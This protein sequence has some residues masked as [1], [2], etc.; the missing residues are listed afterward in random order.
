MT[1]EPFFVE[2]IPQLSRER[3]QQLLAGIT[4]DLPVTRIDAS[5]IGK[6]RAE[7]QSGLAK[8]FGLNVEVNK[9]SLAALRKQI[10]EGLGTLTVNVKGQT[11]GGKSGG[12]GGS[13]LSKEEAA[14]EA[15]AKRDK[16]RVERLGNAVANLSVEINTDA[17][18]RDLR[19][20]TE[21]FTRQAKGLRLTLED[22]QALEELDKIEKKLAAIPGLARKA[23]DPLN[24]VLPKSSPL[25][26]AQ[27]RVRR[28]EG[29]DPKDPALAKQ[30]QR[31]QNRVERL[32]LETDKPSEL[33]AIAELNERV[34]VVKSNIV[35]EVDDAALAA[36]AEKTK[37]AAERAQAAASASAASAASRQERDDGVERRRKANVF[38]GTLEVLGASRESTLGRG[39][40]GIG[41]VAAEVGGPAA[42]VA[43]ASRLALAAISNYRKLAEEV[44]DVAN[45]TGLAATEAS[46]L[47]F[48]FKAVQINSN[49]GAK[50]LFQF[51]KNADN[52]ALKNFGINVTR[53]AAGAIDLSASL[54]NVA[55]AFNAAESSTGK[56][57]VLFA[58]FGRQA[59]TLVP[60]LEKGRVG[61]V[62]LQN[63]AKANGLLFTP[64]DLQRARDF[65]KT[66]SLAK[67]SVSGLGQALAKDFVPVL[68]AG[69]RGL[70]DTL[71]KLISGSKIAARS[72]KIG[73]EF[74]L[75]TQTGGLTPLNEQFNKDVQSAV[76]ANANDLLSRDEKQR[77]VDE[78]ARKRTADLALFRSN[79]DRGNAVKGN[80]SATIAITNDQ[81]KLQETIL[82]NTRSRI[83]GLVD[84]KDITTLKRWREQLTLGGT[85][86]DVAAVSAAIDQVT[87]A[88]TKLT[89]QD[90]N[91]SA[92]DSTRSVNDLREAFLAL[93]PQDVKSRAEAAKELSAAVADQ[94]KALID[95]P[96]ALREA[97]AAVRNLAQDEA[98]LVKLQREAS[99]VDPTIRLGAIQ[100]RISVIQA[101][102]Q[103][104]KDID[105]TRKAGIEIV[106]TEREIIKAKGS[107]ATKALRA[108]ADATLALTRLR[109]DKGRRDV[110]L[111]QAEQSRAKAL[112]QVADVTRVLA[113][114]EKTR[115]RA[116]VS[117]ADARVSLNR[118]EE[119]DL[120][121]KKDVQKELEKLNLTAQTQN[122]QAY[123]DAVLASVVAQQNLTSAIAAATVAGEQIGGLT[124]TRGEFE[125]QRAAA[126]AAALAVRQAA[127]EANKAASA[128]NGPAAE[129]DLAK[130]RRDLQRQL[131]DSTK[132]LR[133]ANFGVADSNV[134]VQDSEISLSRQRR[135]VGI[136]AGLG[137]KQAEFGIVDARRSIVDFASD[138]I[139]AETQ[140]ADARQGALDNTQKVVDLEEKLVELRRKQAEAKPG[141][142]LNRLQAQAKLLELQIKE[143]NRRDVIDNRNNVLIPNAKDTIATSKDTVRST[144]ATVT[145]DSRVAG[146]LAASPTAQL[147]DVL[148]SL[149]LPNTSDIVAKSLRLQYAVEGSNV[150]Y[151][152]LAEALKAEATSI[153]KGI[154]VKVNLVIPVA[155]DGPSTVGNNTPGVLAESR[156]RLEAIGATVAQDVRFPQVTGPDNVSRRQSLVV[157]RQRVDSELAVIQSDLQGLER[158][159]LQGA[160]QSTI[161]S[162]QKRI[163]SDKAQIAELRKQLDE[164]TKAIA[165]LPRFAGGSAVP[166]KRYR[167]NELGMEH[168]AT[169]DGRVVPI[170]GG[171]QVGTFK[172]DGVIIPANVTPAVPRTQN[173]SAPPQIIIQ[174]P[175]APREPTINVEHLE[176]HT[177][178]KTVDAIGI[179]G[180]MAIYARKRS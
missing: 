72:I 83:Q 50:A 160:S 104:Q 34:G 128:A 108:E 46:S 127:N 55:D 21:R 96:K 170:M 4:V 39:A 140:I 86:E 143:Q 153:K 1:V 18:D 138:V 155:P 147:D 93:D 8:P 172:M 66:I 139:K 38:S 130:K 122:Q 156:R 148:N 151:S 121:T 119:N 52:P 159:N 13:S 90:F 35:V 20:F 43:I 158:A 89:L 141:D 16:A 32:V 29:V 41:R 116:V 120:Q 42:G 7:I 54:L 178:A 161:Q 79:V 100:E 40:R 110:A 6:V 26:V 98:A 118:A 125:A 77:L 23:L 15:A 133:D 9:A 64:A 164:L 165:V 61:I 109:E 2:L 97:G 69:A 74:V 87:I 154:D 82:A 53:T 101:E 163:A 73:V 167:F 149:G 17:A 177:A 107:D 103:A 117:S 3:V 56:T 80:A 136:D 10:E 51:S 58:A 168:F 24:V 30:A 176:V 19:A 144:R 25:E 14:A 31:V 174:A 78:E 162:N 145:T 62:E 12:S 88:T 111:T 180:A 91:N 45:S 37:A 44:R 131:E 135:D 49:L 152:T 173:A 150:T 75:N 132:A 47:V 123:T 65:E 11:A 68:A 70:P 146:G 94:A 134:A 27:D 137:L 124:K 102:R 84:E 33:A 129:E 92:R 71:D 179:V 99:G 142:E 171:D 95:L 126:A 59:E 81:G 175:E 48:A 112:D 28:L 5:T 115:D 114:A 67:Q 166:G 63:A 22:D 157:Q 36:A 76:G 60:L 113:A 85:K 106:K 169:R 105:V 57:N